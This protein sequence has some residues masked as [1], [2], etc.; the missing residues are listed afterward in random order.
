MEYVEIAIRDEEK[1]DYLEQRSC[2]KLIQASPRATI[3]IVTSL[4]VNKI[5]AA[6]GRNSPLQ[7]RHIHRSQ[8]HLFRDEGSG[9]YDAQPQPLLDA[10][11]HL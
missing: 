1:R 7:R 3:G 11:R 10:G 8:L 4:F 9:D 6:K 5:S 2:R